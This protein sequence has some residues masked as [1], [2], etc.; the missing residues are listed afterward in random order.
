MNALS[1]SMPAWTFDAGAAAGRGLPV[2]LF[3]PSSDNTAHID[4]AD[5]VDAEQLDR[6]A[7]TLAEVIRAWA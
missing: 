5:A 4:G 1:G 6:A 2:V 7:A 3:G